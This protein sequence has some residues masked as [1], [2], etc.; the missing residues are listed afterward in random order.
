MKRRERGGHGVPALHEWGRRVG[1]WRNG[2][3]EERSIG[4]MESLSIGWM[5]NWKT[6]G[7]AY[8]RDHRELPFTF[9][10]HAYVRM[11]QRLARR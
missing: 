9:F 4:V 1:G 10:Y 5:K 6:E 2:G 11:R 7:S 3:V 8:R